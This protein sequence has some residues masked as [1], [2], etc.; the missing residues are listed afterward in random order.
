M[1]VAGRVGEGIKWKK[2]YIFCSVCVF[3]LLNFI[4]FFGMLTSENYRMP[5]VRWVNTTIN[6]AGH[7]WVAWPFDGGYKGLFF[8]FFNDFELKGRNK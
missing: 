7:G 5:L 3:Y 4:P 2:T 1:T 8:F 6:C